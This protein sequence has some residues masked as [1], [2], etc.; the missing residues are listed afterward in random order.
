MLT[1]LFFQ[2]MIADLKA[3]SARWDQERRNHSGGT[4]TSHDSSAFLMRSSKSN[5][6][7]ARY[8]DSQNRFSGA[9]LSQYDTSGAPYSNGSSRDSYE[10]VPR[11]PGS[12][13]PGYSAS[14]A[15]QPY[16]QD[17]RQSG[18]GGSYQQS[19]YPSQAQDNRFPA[20]SASVYGGGQP[21][22][23]NS[24]PT[25]IQQMDPHPYYAA[26]AN[27]TVAQPPHHRPQDPYQDSRDPSR[28]YATPA[29]AYGPSSQAY[30]PPPQGAYPPQPVDAFAGRQPYGSTSQAEILG[31]TSSQAPMYD[32]QYEP[33]PQYEN[34]TP[35]P[36]RP[37]ASSS[38]Q[39]QTGHS[40]SSH[41]RRSDR[42][43][44]RDD[45]PRRR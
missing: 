36:S 17:N 24:H 39:A 35:P 41:S 44:D 18:Y 30:Y 9:G 14:T 10:S 23:S 16:H 34:Q 26:G 37:V 5:S 20:G 19:P 13:A 28:S 33:Q 38:S 22:Y 29:S 8:S 12:D 21:G 27:L 42:E 15:S 1:V 40:G 2:A 7:P 43:R 45:R 32:R 25:N 11:Y 3:D 6:P 31:S 4:L